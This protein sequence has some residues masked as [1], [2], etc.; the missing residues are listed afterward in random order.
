MGVLGSRPDGQQ[1][2]DRMD[3]R[4]SARPGFAGLRIHRQAAT[5]AG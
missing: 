1:V 4:T 5:F 3:R 2:I